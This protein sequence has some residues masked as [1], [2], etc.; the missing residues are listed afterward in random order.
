[1]LKP[2][3]RVRLVS[4]ASYPT[5]DWVEESVAILERWGLVAEVGNHALDKFG[6]MAGTDEDRLKDLNEAFRDPGIRAVITTRGG[7]GA[8]RIADRIDFDPSVPIP[9]RW[10]VS[11][12][13]PS[14]I[15]H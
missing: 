2:G 11:A 7:A 5:A 12:T 6:Y 10:W 3:D 1:M 8:Y 13:S 14:F 15:F 9:N 4:P